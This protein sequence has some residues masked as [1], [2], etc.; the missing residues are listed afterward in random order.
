[1][2]RLVGAILISLIVV[3]VITSR[4]LL[5][6]EHDD[7]WTDGLMPADRVAEVAVD[8]SGPVEV[9]Y[10]EILF[11]PPKQIRLAESSDS[12]RA[13]PIDAY[14]AL[15]VSGRS[16]DR[17]AIVD[18]YLPDERGTLESTLTSE[19][20][21]RNAAIGSRVTDSVVE[22]AWFYR[23]CVVLL[24]R[25][26]LKDGDSFPSF[27]VFR[28]TPGGWFATNQLSKDPYLP[29][30]LEVTWERTA[31]RDAGRARHA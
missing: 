6:P 28:D 4:S 10:Q 17:A 25:H 19:S 22:R 7:D 14:E 2:R 30:L 11:E 29:K 5:R 3:A 12:T 24:L 9:A 18:A 27:A 13:D 23:G 21:A 8:G 16:A 31:A 1:M 26:R 15:T 20:L